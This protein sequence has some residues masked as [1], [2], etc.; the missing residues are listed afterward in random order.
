MSNARPDLAY[1]T[2][3][4]RRCGL[5]TTAHQFTEIVDRVSEESGN[6]QVVRTKHALL[7]RQVLRRI[8]A[9]QVQ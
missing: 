9:R 4:D 8:D 6:P 7:C 5:M 2:S 1:G 3:N